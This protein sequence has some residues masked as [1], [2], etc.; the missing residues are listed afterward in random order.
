MNEDYARLIKSGL[1]QETKSQATAQT[2][3]K[4]LLW[5]SLITL[6]LWFV[7]YSDFALYPLRLF[8]TF[9]HESGHALAAV[10]TGGQV[11]SL[12][13]SP[14]TSGLTKTMASPLWMWL[15]YSGGYLGT[16]VFGALLLQVGRLHR[17]QHA[18]RATLYVAASFMVGATVL[19]VRDPFTLGV[20]VFLA[21]ALFGLAK[22]LPPRA[23]D[24][25]AAFLAVQCSLNAL[26]D[27]R[28]LINLTANHLGDNDAVF[29]A[30]MYGLP[31][32]LWAT[33]WAAMAVVILLVALRS[34]FRAT[35]VRRNGV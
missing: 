6:A 21:V 30:R 27:L 8:I 9:L 15:I 10:A 11:V 33:L 24:F 18:G 23:A 13:V 5:A 7:P 29:M 25:A 20:G 14:N 16:T 35:G 19:W 17:W 31:S 32:V 4:T 1:L 12:S 34:Y 3:R 26:G 22:I 2:S 28:I